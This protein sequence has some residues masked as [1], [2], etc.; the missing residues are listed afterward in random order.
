M[1]LVILSKSSTTHFPL[2]SAG[3][4]SVGRHPDS[5][6]SI[7]DPKASRRHGR[8]TARGGLFFFEDLGTGN[9]TVISSVS[10]PPKTRVEIKEGDVIEIGE[11]QLQ[12]AKTGSASEILTDLTPG[13]KSGVLT[14]KSGAGQGSVFILG[15]EPTLIGRLPICQIQIDDPGSSRINT[16]IVL[17]NSRYFLRDLG[18][19][20]GTLLNNRPV[21]KEVLRSGDVIQVGTHRFM[22]SFAE[23]DEEAAAAQVTDEKESRFA[24]GC[25]T[26][27]FGLISAIISG[28]LVFLYMSGR[29]DNPESVAS[30]A[31]QPGTQEVVPVLVGHPVVADV[32][33]TLEKTGN[34]Q[35]AR[36]DIIPFPPGRKVE[37]VHVKNGDRVRKGEPLVTFE[38]TEELRSARK[39]AVAGLNQ[40][41]EDVAKTESEVAK[42]IAVL[43]NARENLSIIQNTHDRSYRV[44]RNGNLLQKE[45]DEILVKL[46]EARTA[47]KLRAEEKEQAER[48][49]VQAKEK[50]F[51]V[52][53]ELGDVDVMIDDLTITANSA[54]V[55]NRLD[56][57]EGYTVTAINASMELIEYESEVK[58][59]VSVSEDDIISIR[60]NME[61][62]VWLSRAPEQVFRG[63]VSYI[64]P[65]ALNRTYDV[66]ISVP[67]RDY[68]FRPGQQVSVRFITRT[69]EGSVLIP[70]SALDTNNQTGYHVFTIDPGESV[71]NLVPVRR[72]Q[73][74]DHLG[75]KYIE[76]L[77]IEDSKKLSADDLIVIKGNKAVKHGLKVVILNPDESV[78]LPE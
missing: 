65:T 28:V 45:W 13:G 2:K 66:E 54:G 44:Y 68:H 53:T 71:A 73:E 67:N 30:E 34:V 72:G 23:V 25:N 77:P 9:G 8:L 74:V 48:T 1:E 56:L 6:I 50:V 18:S 46:A 36:Q 51:Q 61:A 11:Y 43:G 40:A 58:V 19:S 16:E 35:L 75:K 14:Q 49:I 17:E 20:N 52:Q 10:I 64:P 7:D 42:A 21:K 62:E 4:W 70:L 39:Q 41:R 55:V 69:R 60:K 15:E 24:S 63:K 47:V 29:G 38:L 27:A 26:A 3:T 57:K 32:P 22:F 59:T 76:T 12:L 33:V 31:T 37:T 78:G 5:D